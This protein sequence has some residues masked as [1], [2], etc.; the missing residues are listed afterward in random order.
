MRPTI[1]IPKKF[2]ACPNI[3]PEVSVSTLFKKPFKKLM[4]NLMKR[5]IF[6]HIPTEL[7]QI[8]IALKTQEESLLTQTNS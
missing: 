3:T 7:N 8:F 6:F 5:I 4:S 2:I 1:G